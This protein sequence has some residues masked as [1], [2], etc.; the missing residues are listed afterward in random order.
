MGVIQDS[1]YFFTMFASIA[2]TVL[3]LAQV[4]VVFGASCGSTPIRP[5]LNGFIVGGVEA[6]PH[7]LPWQI[8]LGYTEGRY[9]YT[10]C[11]GSIVSERFVIT[12]AHCIELSKPNRK[13]NV[14]VG[15]HNRRKRDC[16]Y[17]KV[18]VKRVIVHP[19]WNE[20]RIAAGNDIAILELSES[21]RFN[22]AVQPICLA[23]R[24]QSYRE[25]DRFVVSGWGALSEGGRSPDALQ[26][27]VVPFISE[28]RCK[29]AT[30][31]RSMPGQLCAGYLE[32]GK[33]SCQGDSGGPLAAKIDGKW[34]LAGVVSWGVGCARRN[35][36][37]VYTNVGEFRSFIDKYVR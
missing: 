33:D 24:G 30:R 23:T 13:Y 19:S 28:S 14:I 31:M 27:L 32:G 18:D 7:S 36:P 15:M 20:N 35:S 3:C 2:L 1:N 29:R 8:R 17:K 6:R 21:L 9:A 10:M 37:G 34:T 12:A 4:S 22:D 26:Q 5:N 25:S 16:Y 11:G